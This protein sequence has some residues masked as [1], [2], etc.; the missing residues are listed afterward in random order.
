M[1]LLFYG[2]FRW[3][4]DN[5]WKYFPVSFLGDSSEKHSQGF[6]QNP[7]GSSSC[8]KHLSIQSG[9]QH[10]NESLYW[11]C[12]FHSLCPSLLLPGITFQNK[13][14]AFE[15]LCHPFLSVECR[16][17]C[18][19]TQVTHFLSNNF[20]VC[21]NLERVVSTLSNSFI[22]KYLLKLCQ[23][24]F[25]VWEYSSEQ[26]PYLH[27]VYILMREIDT[28]VNRGISNR[29]KCHEIE[30][31]DVLQSNKVMRESHSEEMLFE[32]RNGW[33]G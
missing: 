6:L 26:G 2:H 4:R 5:G 25:W 19:H 8:Q 28:E 14:P 16:L 32:M 30:Q 31:D 11:P 21:T 12:L 20:L 1:G 33:W 23:V 3:L 17:H 27:R 15:P 29:K 22:S 24:L 13:L 7:T 10:D 9:A 18:D